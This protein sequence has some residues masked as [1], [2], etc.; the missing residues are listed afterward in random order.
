MTN[1]SSSN[2]PMFFFSVR[3]GF[4]PMVWHWSGTTSKKPGIR[5]WCSRS[6]NGITGFNSV[7]VSVR[8]WMI[9]PKS[10]KNRTLTVSRVQMGSVRKEG[11]I[12]W[13]DFPY[14]MVMKMGPICRQIQ[15]NMTGWWF[16][17]F[18]LFSHSDGNFI[19]ADFHSII[20]RGRLNRQPDNHCE[21][22][23]TTINVGRSSGN[24]LLAIINH[25]HSLLTIISHE[26]KQQ[27]N[28]HENRCFYHDF[29]Q[30]LTFTINQP[31]DIDIFQ[32]YY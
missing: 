19:I 29:H 11:T 31:D 16:G 15:P 4:S 30:P 24:G 1:M 27:K 18:G 5:P 26:K 23:L 28:H 14:Q 25:Y 9:F 20:F 13:P 32:D 21:S 12:A 17:T 6:L 22:L 10:S 8:V 7:R 2:L 3:W